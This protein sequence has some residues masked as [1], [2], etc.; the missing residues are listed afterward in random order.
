MEKSEELLIL[1]CDLL[2]RIGC[3]KNVIVEYEEIKFE[4]EL[5]Q[6]IAD[7]EVKLAKLK[8]TGVYTIE[9]AEKGRLDNG[10]MLDYGKL[11]RIKKRVLRRVGKAFSSKK[12]CY[13][14]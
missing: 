2:R 6:K 1:K 4:N 14:K 12:R 11:E 10:K 8:N 5:L 13:N 9:D 3:F 7:F